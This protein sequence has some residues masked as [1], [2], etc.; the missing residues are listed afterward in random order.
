MQQPLQY[1]AMQGVG[2]GYPAPG[3]GLYT[4]DQGSQ[5]FM[6]PTS[7]GPQPGNQGWAQPPSAGSNWG[8]SGQQQ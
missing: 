1:P 8:W 4:S 5:Q 7:S 3:R 2:Q 6:Q